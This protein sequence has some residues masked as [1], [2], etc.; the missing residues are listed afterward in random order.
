MTLGE[1]LANTLIQMAEAKITGAEAQAAADLKKLTQEREARQIYVTKMM[2]DI[3]AKII[4]GGVP[5]IK[6]T[7]HDHM[8]WLKNAGRSTASNQTIWNQ[9]KTSL[10]GDGLDIVISEAHDGGGVKTWVEITVRPRSTHVFSNG[11]G[12]PKRVWAEPGNGYTTVEP[13]VPPSTSYGKPYQ[14]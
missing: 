10:K 4:A 3:R 1:Q 14:K 8:T 13:P 12:S 11:A 6:V 9:A 5:F 2:T 7:Q